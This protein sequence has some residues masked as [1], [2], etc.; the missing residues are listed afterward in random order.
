VFNTIVLVPIDTAD[1]VIFSKDDE[2]CT[3]K[4]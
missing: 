2:P 4:F 1:A 3:I